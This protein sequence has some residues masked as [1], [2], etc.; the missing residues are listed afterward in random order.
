MDPIISILEALG[1]LKPTRAAHKAQ[2]RPLLI[3]LLSSPDASHPATAARS[4]ETWAPCKTGKP[5]ADAEAWAEA[6]LAAALVNF[7]GE[8]LTPPVHAQHAGLV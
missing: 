5:L 8:Q 1:K 7:L 6:G 2:A 3:A 4:L